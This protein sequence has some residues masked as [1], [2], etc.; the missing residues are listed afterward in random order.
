MPFFMYIHNSFHRKSILDNIWAHA[1]LV[2][3]NDFLKTFFL[4]IVITKKN[5][6]CDVLKMKGLWQ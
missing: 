4:Q 3:F 2:P 1:T 5:I 6:F